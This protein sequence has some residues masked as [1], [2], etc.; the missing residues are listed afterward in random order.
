MEHTYMG[1]LVVQ[2]ECPNGTI[3]TL[4]QQGGGGTFLGVPDE[5]DDV[6]C[7][8][9]TGQGTPINYCFTPG[10]TDTWVEWVNAQPGWGLTLP[11]GDYEPIDPLAGLMG[12]PLNGVWNLIVTDNWGAD[13]GTV[14]G[15]G[16][17]FDPA[18]YPPVTEF[19]PHVGDQAD[20]SF[21]AAGDPFITNMSAKGIKHMNL[22][23]LQH[24]V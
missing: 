2:V 14:F 12:C 21:W 15:W 6:D 1:D 10:A 20:S 19:T 17:N 13:D 24:V 23:D 18:L 22:L 3:I 9:G 4:H 7:L 5:D 16:L 8:N 11:G